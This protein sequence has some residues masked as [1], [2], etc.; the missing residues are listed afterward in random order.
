MS[1]YLITGASRGIGL[2]LTKQLLDLDPSKVSKVIALSRGN[3]SPGLDDLL[4]THT[5]RLHHVSGAVDD[6]A[7]IKQAAEKVTELLKGNTGLDV[8][9]NNAGVP[10][11]TPDGIANMTDDGFANVLD[12]NVIG[13]HRVT[14]AFLPLLEAGKGKK[15]INV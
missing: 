5:N 4:S 11:Y 2:E 1:T 9:V 15:V 3:P 7:S 8:L 12:V 6:N 13:V 10:S 14:S